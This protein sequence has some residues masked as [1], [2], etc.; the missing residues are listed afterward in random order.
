MPLKRI[1]KLVQKLSPKNRRKHRSTPLNTLEILPPELII[2]VAQFLP[3]SSK[4]LFTLT[5]RTTYTIL[6]TPYWTRLR[7]KDQYSQH[8]DFLSQLSKDLP[9]DYVPCYHC[10]VLHSCKVFDHSWPSTRPHYRYEWKP[11]NK[12]EVLGNVSKYLHIGFQFRT[13]QMAMKQHRLGLDT[14]PWLD[15]LCYPTTRIGTQ[16]GFPSEFR[17]HVR[18]VNDSLLFRST[19]IVLIKPGLTTRDLVYSFSIGPHV[20]LRAHV[21]EANFPETAGCMLDHQHGLQRCVRKSGTL[22]CLAC[23]TEYELSLEECGRFGVA[24]ILI[25]WM[26]L[27]EGKTIWDPRWWSHLADRYTASDVFGAVKGV[28][29]RRLVDRDPVRS[30]FASIRAS[31]GNYRSTGYDVL[32]LEVAKELSNNYFNFPK[33]PPLRAEA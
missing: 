27:G 8:F 10:R 20:S 12:A 1:I 22:T 25:K 21:A 24:A 2:Y 7:A 3:L 18:I 6:G 23:P 31:F 28:S 15:F 30:N 11:C 16:R 4:V 17:A 14:E 9:P 13:F 32:P 29:G 19:H 33:L 5:C 26:D